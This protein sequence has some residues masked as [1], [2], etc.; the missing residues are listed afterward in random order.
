M[1]K[2]LCVPVCLLQCSALLYIK[3]VC[4]SVCSLRSK[5]IWLLTRLD[6]K[7]PQGEKCTRSLSRWESPLCCHH[8]AFLL[9]GHAQWATP[10][11]HPVLLLPGPVWTS[12]AEAA[13]LLLLSLLS[14]L[15]F[16]VRHGYSGLYGGV[17][18]EEGC[19]C[20][21]SFLGSGAVSHYLLCCSPKKSMQQ[22]NILH[23]GPPEASQR[24]VSWDT[25]HY[26]LMQYVSQICSTSQT[27]H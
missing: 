11:T 13:A 19:V 3:D 7:G 26:Q 22:H 25:I 10:H 16:K 1:S 12:W 18:G 6:G 24:F 27:I 4:V 2:L 23:A 20:E 9:T 17:G 15:T 14:H 8:K 5:L 21:K